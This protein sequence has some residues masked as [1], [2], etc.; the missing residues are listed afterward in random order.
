MHLF[1]I[2][3]L[4]IRFNWDQFG[5]DVAFV[6]HASSYAAIIADEIFCLSYST[7][8]MISAA[9]R[10]WKYF[11]VNCL[12]MNMILSC[13]WLLVKCS[14]LCSNYAFKRLLIMLRCRVKGMFHIQYSLYLQHNVEYHRKLSYIQSLQEWIIVRHSESLENTML[15]FQ[16]VLFAFNFIYLTS[17]VWGPQDI[18]TRN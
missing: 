16:S 15:S 4:F 6:R 18:F 10:L 5:W 1:F 13:L 9:F 12:A 3:L 17:K 7:S 2:N 11:E 8:R 14:L